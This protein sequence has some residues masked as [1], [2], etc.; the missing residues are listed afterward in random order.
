MAHK[1]VEGYIKFLQDPQNKPL[2]DLIELAVNED[3]EALNYVEF[4][5]EEIAKKFKS[6]DDG[7]GALSS[8]HLSIK[9]DPKEGQEGIRSIDDSITYYFNEFGK[10]KNENGV[11]NKLSFEQYEKVG[12]ELTFYMF[13]LLMKAYKF[14]AKVVGN[15]ASKKKKKKKK[16]QDPKAEYKFK[17][18]LF[19]PKFEQC[20]SIVVLI[21]PHR[22]AV[23]YNSLAIDEGLAYGTMLPY[24]EKILS[25]NKKN[26]KGKKNGGD[27]DQKDEN[28]VARKWGIMILGMCILYYVIMMMAVYVYMC[29]CVVYTQIHKALTRI[30][31]SIQLLRSMTSG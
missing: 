21:P 1:G 9:I 25:W 7:D 4:I 31:T 2:R 20:D 17:T 19:S 3:E 5:Q 18:I 8:M 30:T 10:L 24:I 12:D 26:K 14:K 16:Q 27:N 29:V 11:D 13:F 28:E 22:G 23:C 15:G 6:V